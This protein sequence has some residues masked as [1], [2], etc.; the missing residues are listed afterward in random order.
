MTR[1]L[2][3]ALLRG[4]ELLAAVL[5]AAVL[6]AAVLF[7]PGA[8]AAGQLDAGPGRAEAPS[9]RPSTPKQRREARDA[10]HRRAAQAFSPFDGGDVRDVV[11]QGQ[12]GKKRAAH[13]MV[14][15]AA[16]VPGEGPPPP[17]LRTSP[18]IPEAALVS[19]NA[20]GAG[21]SASPLFLFSLGYQHVFTKLDGPRCAHLPTCSRFGSQAVARH[22]ALGILMTLDRLI[23]PND[24]SAIRHL[25]EVEGYGM[26]RV[27][28]P[29]EDYE[30]WKPERFTGFL[31]PAAE[32]PLVLP[33]LGAASVAALTTPP[34]E[35]PRP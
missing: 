17:P 26:V 18:D 20:V 14:G 28:D 24:S 23:Q 22:G 9:S 2:P 6:L 3:A 35:T 4:A 11:R 13:P 34:P 5:L 1:Y 12:K 32:V 19:P 29:L 31:L 7:A 27:F 15:D 33:P 10:A 25:P 30:L 8:L 21:L 16:K